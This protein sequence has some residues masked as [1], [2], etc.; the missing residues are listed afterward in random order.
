MCQGPSALPFRDRNFEF[1][2]L[3]ELVNSLKKKNHPTSAAVR[4]C[5]G[6]W[7]R[8]LF[9]ARS[10]PSRAYFRVTWTLDLWL[11]HTCSHI[12]IL[13]FPH[14]V[15][16]FP[17]HYPLPLMR[18]SLGRFTKP[19]CLGTSSVLPWITKRAAL[20]PQRLWFSWSR[21]SLGT[22]ISTKLPGA[23]GT[24]CMRTTF[25]ITLNKTI[26]LHLISPRFPSL[27]VSTRTRNPSL[28]TLDAR[29]ARS[30]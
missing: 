13:W 16:P 26:S 1:W 24:A 20:H 30:S 15:L 8:C 18:A 25:W 11:S 12:R 21:N 4:T 27:M 7:S 17:T 10:A 28:Q 23:M 22:Y 9:L 29:T 6:W 5:A 2:N 3:P 14:H 19:Y